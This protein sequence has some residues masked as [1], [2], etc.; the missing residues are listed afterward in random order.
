MPTETLPRGFHSRAIPDVDK[1]SSLIRCSCRKRSST[2][3]EYINRA[4]DAPTSR[5]TANLTRRLT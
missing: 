4:G 5:P 2:L 1:G 3:A